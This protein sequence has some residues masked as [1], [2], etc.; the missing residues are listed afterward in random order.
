MSTSAEVLLGVGAIALGGAAGASLRY[1]VESVAVWRW[2]QSW[3]WGTFAVNILGSLVLGALL[4]SVLAAELPRWASLMLATGFCGALTTFSSFALQILDM[5]SSAQTTAS[6]SSH[7]SL[8]G[9][10]YAAV[11]LGAGLLAA[12]LI[13]ALMVIL[14]L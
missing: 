7:F 14:G 11:S 8:R 12:V 3:P 2:G 4:G 6:T 9:L 10:A 13:P 1:V 5:S